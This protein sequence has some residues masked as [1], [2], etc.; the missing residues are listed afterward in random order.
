M[1]TDR[2]LEGA[3]RR[4]RV[5]VPAGYTMGVRPRRSISARIKHS[6]P[7]KFSL[8]ATAHIKRLV[9]DPEVRQFTKDVAAIYAGG[10]ILSKLP[11]ARGK[12]G[13]MLMKKLRGKQARSFRPRINLLKPRFEFGRNAPF[14]RRNP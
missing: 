8:R 9:K 3:W 4:P 2:G 7:G 13:T 6:A 14:M 11:G 12:L 1:A 10:Y 5:P